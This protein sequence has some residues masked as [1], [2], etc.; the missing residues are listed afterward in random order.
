LK[1]TSANLFRLHGAGG[2]QLRC[3]GLAG[4]VGVARDVS[5]A[6]LHDDDLACV[7][8]RILEEHLLFAIVCDGDGRD[9]DVKLALADAG[10]DRIEGRIFNA[11]FQ[12]SLVRDQLDQFDVKAGHFLGLFIHVFKRRESGI[13]GDGNLGFGALQ[14][15]SSMARMARIEMVNKTVRF[16]LSS[17]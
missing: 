1:V 16:T 11:D 7:D 13:G 3:D 4:Q 17:R 12:T 6:R 14:A 15:V 5:I 9:G 2:A 8:I 10:R